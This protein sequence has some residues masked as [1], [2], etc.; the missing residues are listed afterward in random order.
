MLPIEVT[1]R[2]RF[3]QAIAAAFGAEFSADPQIKSGDPKFAD[4]QCNAAMGL[5]RLLSR[6][7]REI[8]GKIVDHLSIDDMFDTPQI[9]GPGFINV[10]IKPGWLTGELQ[11]LATNAGE[12][13]RGG[14]DQVSVPQAVVV[15]YAG[16]NIAKE[17]HVGHL[18]SAIIGDSIARTLA[19]LGHVVIRQNHV[20]DFGT[21]FGMLIRHARDTAM[22]GTE[23]RITD[24]DA[25]YKQAS[26]RDKS[27]PEFAIQARQAVV[28]L[29]QGYPEAVRLW[30]WIRDESRRHCRE[31]FAMLGVQLTDADERGE[32][33]YKDRL[34]AMVEHLKGALAFGGDGARVGMDKVFHPS[35]TSP[36]ILA[37]E[38]AADSAQAKG[39]LESVEAVDRILEAAAPLVVQKPFLAESEGALCVFLPGYVDKD[40]KPLPL[41]IRKSDGAFL[42][43]TTDLAALYFRVQE[44]KNT[45][46]DKRP[47]DCN[48]HAHRIIYTTDS[49][50]SQHFAMVFDTIRAAR[51]DIHP[52]SGAAVKLEHAP[53]GS[54]LGEDGKPFKTR[55]GESVKLRELLDEAVARAAKIVAEK[56]PHLSPEKQ[57]SIARAVGVGAVK[58]AD[59]RQD[60]TGDYAFSW[61]RM[62]S[63]E[64]NTG[65]YLQYTYA[66]T[67]S[68]F[69]KAAADQ[70]AV[71]PSPAVGEL[72]LEHPR[73]IALGRRLC[74]F[75]GVVESA[76]RDLKPHFICGFLYDLAGDFSGFWEA[77]PVLRAPSEAARSSRLLLCRITQAVLAVG[78]RDLLGIEILDE[79]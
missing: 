62:L 26:Q 71:P 78:L 7:P 79:M 20:G 45:A 41:I 28:E 40:K 8:A 61:D 37:V 53:F 6:P 60:R 17:M 38:P 12:L 50:Q 43:A 47:L 11:S 30:R 31:L 21:Q 27:D 9:A 76:A 55:S 49:R 63:F 70:P 67:C 75:S 3:T 58:Y 57:A 72:R 19:F 48:W 24:L 5:S 64:G 33:F 1:L 4:Y 22:Q 23:P 69:R 44:D 56:S 18:R 74:Q 66:R 14:V 59:L 2:L 65:P 10:R 15:D 46:E 36:R 13:A 25:Y 34:A 32:S 29:Q 42:Y 52:Q 68:I 51:W 54:I 35:D 16:P 77:C 39:A 73:E